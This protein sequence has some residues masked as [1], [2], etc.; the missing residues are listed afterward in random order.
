MLQSSCKCHLLQPLPVPPPP[1]P[2]FFYILPED[3]QSFYQ[4]LSV[5]AGWAL[6][7]HLPEDSTRSPVHPSLSVEN[8]SQEP[9]FPSNITIPAPTISISTDFWTVYTIL[10]NHL[11]KQISI[12]KFQCRCSLF[13]FVFFCCLF[14]WFWVLYFVGFF[15]LFVFGRRG[16][17]KGGW[18]EGR[19][20]LIVLWFVLNW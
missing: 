11:R 7:P 17:R 1:P 16:G 9:I 19:G 13:P 2:L 18:E 5:S 14:I 15:G 10:N 20:A 8:I 12:M 4:Q 3:F 6:S